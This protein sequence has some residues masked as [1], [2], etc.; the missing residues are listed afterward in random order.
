[1]EERFSLA[2]CFSLHGAGRQDREW[3]EFLQLCLPAGEVVFSLPALLITDSAWDPC[4]T[5]LA[6]TQQ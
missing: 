1:M 4:E 3:S 5:S 2:L 6:V